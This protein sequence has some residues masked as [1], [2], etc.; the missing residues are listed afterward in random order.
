M[1]FILAMVMLMSGSAFAASYKIDPAHSV[2][3]FSVKHLVV[4]KVKGRF[5]KFEGSFDFDEKKNEVTKIDVKIDAASI[6]TNEKKRD[7]HLMS[8]DFFDV[9]KQS[10]ILFKA[11]KMSV[12]KD[13]AT[14]VNGLL[15]IKGVT[16]PV[17][18]DLT[19]G[20]SIVD[21]NGNEKVG[22][23]L[24]GKIDRKDFGVSWN[25]TLD[26]GGVA[27]SDEVMIEIE[28]EAQKAK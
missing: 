24:A 21:P 6:D 11:D 4:S 22:F 8:A 18:L 9:K 26:K 12:Q 13:K 14:K 27:V 15:T 23:S 7:E 16:K 10:Q 25:K 28:G 20:G 5:N 3:G 1:K 17:T 2:V 19:Y